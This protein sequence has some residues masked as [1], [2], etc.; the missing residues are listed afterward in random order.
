M[1][2][3]KWSV[4]VSSVF[5]QLVLG[6][7]YIW[8]VFQPEVASYY[9][10][11]ISTAAMVFSVM[12]AFI[13]LG[14]IIGGKLQDMY[15]PR[16]VVIASGILIG[17][18]TYMT[19]Y[20]KSENPMFMYFSYGALA[21]SG[22]GAIYTT[23]IAVVQKWFKEQKGLATGIVLG[24]LG[25]GGVVFTPVA[26]MLLNNGGVP[27][28]FMVLGIVF[29]IICTLGGV[30]IVNPEVEKASEAF[31]I[32][33]YTT[34]Q[35]L[36]SPKYYVLVITMML[37]LPAFF[38]VSPLIKVLCADRGIS[39]NGAVYVVMASSV[40]N[41]CGRFIAPLISKRTGE[42][43]T[44]FLLNL[45]TIFA[46]LGMIFA[47]KWMFVLLICLIAVCFGGFLG[48]FPGMTSG[49]FGIKNAASNY[50]FVLIGYGLS[51][52]FAPGI[53]EFAM[54]WGMFAPFCVVAGC[55]IGAIAVGRFIDTDS[56]K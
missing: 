32:T 28:T 56:I 4:L 8:G 16:P 27:V 37:S 24:A 18:G 9:G 48:V 54:R 11:S 33:G 29:F 6:V 12:I 49:L 20:T 14:S 53:Y 44:I 23:T 35:M 43:D 45:V 10:W 21:G 40:L 25:F 31:D 55:A 2:H 34:V 38:M 39:V 42:R 7:I 52:I 46:S 3:S 22:I 1:K 26:Q 50:G 13:V 30:F 15:S 51:A 19:A 47:Y 17:L 36:R 5:M 41:C